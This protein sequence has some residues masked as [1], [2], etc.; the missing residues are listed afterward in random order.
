MA[1]LLYKQ[2]QKGCYNGVSGN[3]ITGYSYGNDDGTASYYA[4]LEPNTTYT[5]KRIDESTR[6]R[7]ATY[8]YDVKTNTSTSASVIQQ[9]VLDSSDALTFTTRE[10]DIHLVV[11]YTNN[12]EYNTR[13]MLNEGDTIQP[14]EAPTRNLPSVWYV[15]D[16][17]LVRDTLPEPLTGNYIQ[18]PYPPFWW[19]VENG[20]LTHAG[21]PEPLID[22]AFSGCSELRAVSI[23]RSVK[24][25]GANA[26]SGTALKRVRI[27]SDCAYLKSSFPDG[28]VVEFYDQEQTVPSNMELYR[29]IQELQEV[30]K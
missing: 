2:Y 16:G 29:M 28:C 9:W 23:P 20:R 30:N 13:V 7:I 27:A 4:D 21:L 22:G 26:F 10:N 6:F 18:A 5:I 19:Y 1:N 14:Y 11:Y 12:N 15:R 24:S 3:V 8:E 17:R 25:I